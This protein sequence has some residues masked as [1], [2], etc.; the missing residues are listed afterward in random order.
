MLKLGKRDG[1]ARRIEALWHIAARG[2]LQRVVVCVSLV[3]S[4]ALMVA[5]LRAQDCSAPLSSRINFPVWFEYNG[6]YCG[7]LGATWVPGT[8]GRR[9]RFTPYYLKV[10]YLNRTIKKT[11]DTAARK[12]LLTRRSRILELMRQHT[13][14][15]SVAVQQGANG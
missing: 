6:V 1:Q 13:I 11:T 5:D 9:R 10:R 7:Q 14:A 4:L 8:I 15:C 3:F 2:G 12:S